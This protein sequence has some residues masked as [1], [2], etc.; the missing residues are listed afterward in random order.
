MEIDRRAFLGVLPL[1]GGMSVWPSFGF[2]GEDK[3]AALYAAARRSDKGQFSAALFNEVG[4]ILRIIALP[5]RGHDFAVRPGHSELVVF[6]RRPGT[7]AIAFSPDKTRAPLLFRAKSSRHFYGHG[8][9]SADGRL[10]YSTEND[11]ETSVGVIGVRD[12]TNG[13][14]QIGEFP[15]YGIGPH[16]M[17]L[18]ADGETLVIA[19]GGIETSPET[20]RQILNLG[21]MAPSLVYVNRWTGDLIEKHELPADIRQLSIRHLTVAQNN[22]VIFGC[23]YKGPKG[24]RPALMGFH[25]R[26]GE[27]QLR[28]AAHDIHHQ[29]QNYVGSVT[30]DKTGEIIAASH[31]QGGLITFWRSSDLKLLG[32]RVMPDGCGVAR[33][34]KAQGFLLSSGHGKLA[35]VSSLKEDM[36]IV[37]THKGTSFDNHMVLVG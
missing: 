32:S 3:K 35:E 29:M 33:T 9:F 34:K 20:G 12:A 28:E 18:L 25:D 30:A 21:E 11:H 24:D 5:A 4:E 13:Y 22:R 26:G 6:A 1:L 16:D 19:N 2:A 37:K 14:K 36:A 23:Q 7:F 17:A 8:V 15:S 10:L 31:P 27:L